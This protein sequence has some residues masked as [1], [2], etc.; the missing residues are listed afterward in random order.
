MIAPIFYPQAATGSMM[1]ST[2]GIQKASTVETEWRVTPGVYRSHQAAC[3][4]SMPDSEM[5]AKKALRD[6]SI[7]EGGH[8]FYEVSIPALDGDPLS[9]MDYLVR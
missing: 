5:L 2:R 4:R 9:P 3:T 1:W 7:Q 8:T 6:V